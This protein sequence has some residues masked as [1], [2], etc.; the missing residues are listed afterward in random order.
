MDSVRPALVPLLVA[1]AAVLAGTGATRA[2]APATTPT[3]IPLISPPVPDRCPSPKPV[4]AVMKLPPNLPPGEPPAVIAFEQQML[5]YLVAHGYRD[6]G[7]CADKYVRDTGPYVNKVALGTHNSVRIYY[8]PEVIAWLRAGRHGAPA[9]G[10]VIIKEQYPPPAARYGTSADDLGKLDPGEW[11]IMIR[12]SKASRDG[13]FWADLYKGMPTVSGGV[14]YPNA[15][16]GLYCLRCHASAK[17]ATTFASLKNIKGFAGD[18]IIFYHD[19]SWR[20]PPP[21]PTPPPVATTSQAM[22]LAAHTT[23]PAVQNA[24]PHPSKAVAQTPPPEPVV[25][26]PPEPYD[27]MLARPTQMPRVHFLTSDQCMGCHS[28]A[29]GAPAGPIMWLTP[30]PSVS[31]P[32]VSPAPAP[33]PPSPFNVSPYGEWRWSPMGLAGRDPVFFSQLESEIQFI[34]SI[35][36]SRIEGHHPAQTRATLKQQVVDTCMRCHGVMGKRTNEADHPGAHFDEKWVFASWP[37]PGPDFARGEQQ[38]HYGGLARDGISCTVCHQITQTKAEDASLAL[39]LDKKATGL[40]DAEPQFTQI[41]GPFDTKTIAAHPMNEA[42]G[43]KPVYGQIT[44]S[45]RLCASCHSIDLPVVDA[46]DKIRPIAGTMPLPEPHDVEQNTYVEWVNSKFQTE[47]PTPGQPGQSCQQC[48]MPS[49]VPKDRL[50]VAIGPIQTKIAITEDEHYPEADYLAP[51]A[52]ITDTFRKKGFVRHE[53]LGLNAFLLRTFQKNAPVLGVRTDDYMSGSTQ[54]LADAIGNVVRQAEQKTATIAVAAPH[55]ESDALVT[56]VTVTNLTGH[57]FPSGVGFRRAFVELDVV[58]RNDNVLWASGMTNHQGMIVNGTTP[59]SPVLPTE[60]LPKGVYQT[61]RD[62]RHPVTSSSQ[63]QI[64]E[65]LVA[66][67]SGD[68]TESFIR[69]DSIVKDDR[70]LP[71]GWRHDGPRGIP[72]PH[73]WL[74]ATLPKGVYVDCDAHPQDCD[75]VF[76]DGRGHAKVGYR[77]ALRDIG[78]AVDPAQLRVRATLWYQSWEPKFVHDRTTQPG[79]AGTRLRVLLDNLDLDKTAMKDWKLKIASASSP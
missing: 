1:L 42:L 22:M 7:W 15:G 19:D 37:S 48:H 14:G 44:T 55:V 67:K 65:E 53:L 57:R 77:I 29:S 63:V 33:T 18:P 8:S 38:F 45:A 78:T 70:I 30:P 40:F 62:L 71:A 6:L 46:P 4:P 9:D 56:S 3:A 26:F 24:H 66:D 10:A 74:E 31:A 79:A 59:E 23:A 68:F 52:D 2:A 34:A 75:R 20:T 21:A 43:I 47:Y 39:V 54:D 5:G 41:H 58:D 25:T 36:D 51:I 17:D 13:W 50:G 76:S 69:R 49:S 12:D 11:T 27:Q 72:L 16:Y 61:H 28:A 64:F 60:I 73:R 32:A 35:P